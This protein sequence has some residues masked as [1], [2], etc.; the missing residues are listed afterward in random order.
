[1]EGVKVAPLVSGFHASDMIDLTRFTVGVSE[2]H[3][4]AENTAKT[5]GTL[6]VTDGALKATITLFGKYGAAGFHMTWD[7]TG[8]T[9]ITYV[10]P[11]SAHADIAGGHT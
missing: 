1:M 9:A 7:G 5:R 10:A 8:G 6:T 2:K 3:I 11:A 4:F